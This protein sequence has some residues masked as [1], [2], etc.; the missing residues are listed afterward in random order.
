MHLLFTIILI[1][2][3]LSIL[4]AQDIL[5]NISVAT[6][7]N[8]NAITGNPAGLGINRGAQ[9]GAYVPFDSTFSITTSS[10][11]GGFGYDL[12]FQLING[13]FSPDIEN[14]QNIAFNVLRHRLIKNY[15]AD[16]ELVT[17][18]KIISNLL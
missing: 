5:N 17:I 10:R 7:D 13:K 14:V 1:L 16:A 15:K 11:S 8:L 2:N 18:D 9:Y 4:L 12:T 6:S 3:S